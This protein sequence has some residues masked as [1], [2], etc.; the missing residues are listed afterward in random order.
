MSLLI[1]PL[2]E[3]LLLAKTTTD[4]SLLWE[5]HKSPY[6]NVR[7]AVARNSNIDS[8]IADN[9][10]ADPVLNVSYMAKLSSKA[11]KNREFRTTLTDCVLCEKSE[12]DL[13]CI[14]CEKF[15]NNMI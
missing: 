9:L 13:N 1:R 2:E 12:L 10:I 3:Q 11:T 15:N 7:R 4:K 14:E 5:L 6:M 8:D